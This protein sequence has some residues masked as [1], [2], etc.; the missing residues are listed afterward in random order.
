MGLQPGD[1]LGLLYRRV[2]N[3]LIRRSVARLDVVNPAS[4]AFRG[5][6]WG[7]DGSATTHVDRGCPLLALVVVPLDSHD[8]PVVHLPCAAL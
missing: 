7:C 5:S 2:A 1:L 4:L 6:A 8:Q 3:A